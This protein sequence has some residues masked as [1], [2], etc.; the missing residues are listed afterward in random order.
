[1]A[2]T[3]VYVNPAIA[4]NSGTGTIGDPYGDLQYALDTQARDATNGDQFNIKAG[5]AEVLA[6]PLSLA[7]YGTPTDAAPLI[8]RGC[9]ATANDGGFG[10][11]DC[12]GDTLWAGV[13]SHCMLLHLEIHDGGDHNLV[14][15]GNSSAGCAAIECELHRG[16]SSPSGKALVRAGYSGTNAVLGCYIHDAGTGG[17]GIDGYDNIAKMIGNYVTNCPTGIRAG[18]NGEVSKNIVVAAAGGTGINCQGAGAFVEHNI[19]W[20]ATG[21]TGSGIYTSSVTHIHITNNIVCNFSGVAGRGVYATGK[22]RLLGHNAFYNNATNED[23]AAAYFDLGNDVSLA[24]D[25]FT[26]A[27]NGDFSLTA[28]AKAALASKGWPTSYLGAHANTVPNLNIGP[29]QLAASGGASI[30]R[31]VARLLGG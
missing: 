13:Y 20:S 12:D 3:Q 31:R 25:P 2:I 28:A 26:D 14:D 27:A 15:F 18:S 4:G 17:I 5:T 11:I 29:I 21:N 16:A 19:V 9:S 8:I 7:T 10:E 22:L 1:V 23:I 30:Y 24:A 6:A